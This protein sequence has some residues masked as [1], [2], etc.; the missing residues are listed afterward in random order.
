MFY[1][2]QSL[3]AR[4]G[5]PV[6]AVVRLFVIWQLRTFDNKVF[7]FTLFVVMNWLT[8]M[9]PQNFVPVSSYRNELT[10]A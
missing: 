7:F 8:L 4:T 2:Q 1:S 9:S 5:S 3:R 6:L 10:K